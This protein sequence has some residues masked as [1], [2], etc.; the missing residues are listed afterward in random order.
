MTEPTGFEARNKYL[1]QEKF[2]LEQEVARLTEQL[3]RQANDIGFLSMAM[4]DIAKTVGLPVG[5]PENLTLA[6]LAGWV[7]EHWKP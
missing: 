7:K 2:R 1:A 4:L 6:N 5:P 3:D